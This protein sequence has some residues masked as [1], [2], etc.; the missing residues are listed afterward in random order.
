MSESLVAAN[1]RQRP[2]RTLVSI[3]GVA[4]GVVLIVMMVGLSHG[5]LH[6]QGKRNSNVGAE[7]LFSRPGAYGPG[8]SAVLA[9]PVQ[10][11]PRLAQVAGV[12]AVSPVGQYLKPSSQSF[13][14]ELVEG[15]DYE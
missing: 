9:L 14:V 2:V 10:Y 13:G 15:V 5:M 4:L 11:A 12:K 6:E 7:I 8:T 3:V 1:V